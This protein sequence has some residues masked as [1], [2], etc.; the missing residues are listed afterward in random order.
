MKILISIILSI[1][2]NAFIFGCDRG[3]ETVKESQK[4][5]TIQQSE[6]ALSKKTIEYY[7]EDEVLQARKKF[8]VD[9]LEFD[10]TQE[11]GI[12]FPY[13][14]R[15]RLRIN[16]KSNIVLPYLTILTKRYDH[17]GKMIG[18]SRTPSI[19]TSNIKPGE[20]L[21]YEYYPKGHLPGVEK[22]NVE[23]EHIIANDEKQ[24]FKELN[25]QISK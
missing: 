10:A 18:S 22:I 1:S 24:F 13:S 12:D 9:V 8:K 4:E 11:Y 23:I 20:S 14:D 19:P 2:F 16:N 15:V 17:R 7:T 3:R 6:E 25:M 5:S 21:E